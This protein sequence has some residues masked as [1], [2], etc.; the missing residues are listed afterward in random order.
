MVV[1]PDHL[2]YVGD[3][4]LGEQHPAEDALLRGDVVRGCP[5]ELTAGSDLGDTH[6]AAPPL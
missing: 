3:R 5:L 6:Q 4:V 2:D 1:R